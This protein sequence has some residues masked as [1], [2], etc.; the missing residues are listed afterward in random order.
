MLYH[1]ESGIKMIEDLDESQQKMIIDYINPE[2][3]A[4]KFKRSAS[5][6]TQV[7]DLLNQA[8]Y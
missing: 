7:K 5:T 1:S 2:Q 6:V 3:W 8:G 4:I